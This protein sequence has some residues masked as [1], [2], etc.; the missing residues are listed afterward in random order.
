MYQVFQDDEYLGTFFLSQSEEP[1]TIAATAGVRFTGQKNRERVPCNRSIRF[2]RE[3][4]AFF[5]E[6][7]QGWRLIAAG[8][9][10]NVNLA[11]HRDLES[12]PGIGAKL[13][14]KI[15]MV[16]NCSAGFKHIDD[17]RQIPGIGA[18]KLEQIAPYLE[19]GP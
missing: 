6:K 7:T 19:V 11:D 10:I 12:V 15:I 5:V 14:D 16:R 9:P 1:S 4:T 8:K 2:D 17:L 3:G 18:K 13:A